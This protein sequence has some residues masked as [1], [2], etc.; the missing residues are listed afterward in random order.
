MKLEAIDTP[1]AVAA[2]HG[3]RAHA[4]ARLLALILSRPLKPG[5]SPI[6]LARVLGTRARKLD[7][8]NGSFTGLGRWG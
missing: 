3:R 7:P 8:P 1:P 4:V 5:T 2:N 6:S